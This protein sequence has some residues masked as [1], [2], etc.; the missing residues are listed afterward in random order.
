MAHGIREF[1]RG[2]VQGNTW[3]GL[4]QY[5]TQ[6]VPVTPEQAREVLG[7]TME[8]RR[9][10]V[11]SDNP[12]HNGYQAVPNGYCIVR[13][14]HDVV[15]ASYVGRR[16]VIQD[17]SQLLNH[18]HEEVMG[19]YPGLSIESVGTLHNGATA[20]ICLKADEHQ[21]RGDVSPTI[22]RMMYYNPVGQGSYGIGAHSVRIVCNNTLNASIRE[23][24]GNGSLQR[25]AHTKSAG[26]KISTAM[27]EIAGMLLGLQE[28]K[29]LME[30]L[31]ATRIDSAQVKR[32]LDGWIP[33][34][35]DPTDLV[36]DTVVDKRTQLLEVYETSGLDFVGDVQVS[37]YALLQAATYLVDH[38]TETKTR[39]RGQL[40]WDGLV[41]NRAQRKQEALQLITAL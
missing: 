26:T 30:E 25:I 41:G 37:K 17:N 16:Y 15:L 33:M 27:K 35:V 14:D 38:E 8:K 6:D 32:F 29:L 39:D 7:Y 34:P 3:H 13:P 10:F 5:K 22:S 31:A 40:A 11:R 1:D 2:Y 9:L 21:I 23:A 4:A 19:S 24:T 36:L 20:F 12:R 28:Q 18:I